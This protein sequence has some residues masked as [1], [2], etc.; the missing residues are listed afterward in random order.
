MARAV[1]S[2]SRADIAMMVAC[3]GLSL[4]ATILPMSLRE[5]MAAGLRQTVLAPVIV[6]QTHAERVRAAFLTRDATAA[7]IDSLVL[8]N[9]ELTSLEH[10]N[11][12]LRR[13]LGLAR[14]LR[15]G[16][17]PAEALHGPSFGDE[18]TLIVT[19]GATSG[20]SANVGVVAPEGLV[21]LVKTVDPA[22]STAILWTH[23]DFR[24]SATAA[25]GRVSGIVAPHLGADEDRFL[26]ELRGV[27]YSDSLSPGMVVRTSGL[28]S[29]FPRGIVIGTV[30]R[31][32]PNS[33][34]GWS[35]T[36]LVRPAVLPSDVTHVMVLLP[37]RAQSDLEGVWAAPG[38]TD[39]A[40]AG[41][42]RAADSLAR[43]AARREAAVRADSQAALL[44]PRLDTV[45]PPPSSSASGR[46]NR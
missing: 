9:A 11:D 19:A 4:L 44:A 3:A 43:D 15:W 10:E 14:Q 16:F 22:T 45:P 13:S 36:Y 27:A 37:S 12:R 7:R 34:A 32:L 31:E 35:R 41:V 25:N 6:L 20:I 18:H 28:G 39:S 26:L 1:R 38:G 5:R 8:R 2:G 30:L 40:R 33:Q 29:V 21:G 46:G 17:V 42:L 24:A 23:P